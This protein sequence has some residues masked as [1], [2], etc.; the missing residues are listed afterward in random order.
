MVFAVH[1]GGLVWDGM[2]EVVILGWCGRSVQKLNYGTVGLLFGMGE[3]IGWDMFR[4]CWWLWYL[5]L[6]LYFGF[7]SSNGTKVDQVWLRVA[8]CIGSWG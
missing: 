3:G 2:L 4:I 7:E 1:F 6:E 8:S 5:A